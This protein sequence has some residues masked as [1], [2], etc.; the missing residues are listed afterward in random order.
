MIRHA[1][2]TLTL[3]LLVAGAA[4]CAKRPSMSQ[5]SAPAPSG[6]ST[7]SLTPSAPSSAASKSEPERAASAQPERATAGAT[8]R[9]LAP[10]E[11]AAIDDVK[12][13]HF[14]FDKYAIR[15]GDAKILEANAT[16]LKTNA[17]H[18][19]IVEGHADERGTPEYNLTLGERRAR[20][21]L[22]YLTAQ[23]VRATRM[24]AISYGESRP[25]CKE[26]TEAC[27]AKN[28]R[29]HFLVKPQ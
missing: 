3:I 6:P 18:A 13:I 11:F 16:W 27:W 8:A 25:Q 4:G 1:L 19:V 15:P 14:D 26:S 2:L 24:T 17:G 22:N 9:R 29:A 23:G 20:A 10:G 12:D 28:R 21:A 7:Q 5:A